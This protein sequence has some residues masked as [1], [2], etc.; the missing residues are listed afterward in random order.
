MKGRIG[1]SGAGLAAAFALL[2]LNASQAQPAPPSSNPA[3]NLATNLVEAGRARF[4]IRCAG[5]HGQDGLGGERAPA[6]ANG[7]RLGLDNDKALRNLI[8]HGMADK[9]MPAFSVPAGE[10]DQLAAFALSRMQPLAKTALSGDV[11]AGAAL[12][13]GKCAQC[14]M[15]WG[16]GS[17]N[18]PDL[19][20]A[21]RK[22][23]LAQMETALLKPT[24]RSG[25]YQVATVR[26]A[27]GESL[28]GFIRNESSADL[29]M[30]SFDGRLHLLAKSDLVRIDREPRSIMPAWTG[31]REDMRDLIKFLQAAPDTPAGG[32]EPKPV[33]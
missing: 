25:G 31:S 13:F 32:A 26:T 19:T 9:G 20:E 2:I 10:L 3:T 23:T 15:I 24:A 33:P 30:Q 5:C 27:K 8:Q 1:L 18:G 17:L 16:R 28:R 12:F 7:S 14:H 22:L 29:Q 11:K 4:N 6:I 21:A